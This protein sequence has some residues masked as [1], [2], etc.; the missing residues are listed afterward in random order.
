MHTTTNGMRMQ[1]QSAQLGYSPQIFTIYMENFSSSKK[2]HGLR[3]QYLLWSL[4]MLS[5][6]NENENENECLMQFTILFAI[7]L[8]HRF[9]YYCSDVHCTA[10]AKVLLMRPHMNHDAVPGSVPSI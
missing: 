6:A 1:M 2:L 7:M 10:S 5:Y 4:Q 3:D 8:L 9:R